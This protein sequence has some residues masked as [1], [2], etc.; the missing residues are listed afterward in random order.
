MNEALKTERQIRAESLAQRFK[1]VGRK[2]VVLEFAGV[3]KAGKTTSLGQ[4][5][6][7]LKR[8]GFRVETVVERASVCPIRDKKHANFN[9]WTACTTLA[10]ILEKTQTPPRPEDPDILIL[11]RGLFDS[12]CWLAMMERLSRLRR[13]DLE[14]MDRFL[15]LD[16][17]RKRI[18]VVFVLT[19]SPEDSLERE[20][21]YLPVEG[22]AGSIMNA[23]VLKKTL[24]TTR[25]MAKRLS[26]DFRIHVIDTSSSDLREHPRKTAE[27]VADLTLAVIE[28]QLREEVLCVSRTILSS[29]FKGATWLTEPNAR[30]VLDCFAKHGRFLPRDEAEGNAELV[31]AIPAVIVRNKSGDVLRLRRK[32]ADESNPLHEKL[33][34]WAG[35]H[36]R[37]ED[38]RN[39]EA[40]SRG[41]VRELQEELRLSVESEEL[42]LLGSVYV[43]NGERTSKHVALVYEW[44]AETDDIAVAL[45][46]AEFF[47]RKGNSL[48]GRFVQ[49]SVLVEELLNSKE[50]KLTEVW[51]REI[52]RE[53]LAPDRSVFPPRLF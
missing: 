45:S 14:V 13:E 8:C 47:E 17:W 10:Q 39:G 18:S 34:L 40:V 20:K 6:T 37:V 53:F 42:R 33:V 51:S 21:G 1:R 19:A 11:D 48:S 30:A 46:N 16:D 7:F 44:R 49:P 25:E 12:L 22:A 2:P 43:P 24:D 9:V 32:E 28:E 35:G 26:D 29:T 3:P 50:S 5:Q 23:E 38:G 27:A 31:Q 4:L 52:I 15:R 36:V 41:A